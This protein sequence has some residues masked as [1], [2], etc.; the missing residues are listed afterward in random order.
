MTAQ[1]PLLL[2]LALDRA[3]NPV[4]W[5][6]HETA[7]HL[8]SNDRVL[9]PMSDD[10]RTFYGGV[11]AATGVRSRV[12][13]SSIL[14]TKTRVQPHLWAAD[15]VP[16][17]TNRALF[18]RDDNLCLY[19]G[20]SFPASRLTRDHVVP[21]SRNGPDRWENVVTACRACNAQ[22]G[23]RTPA[24]WGR[25]LIA[26]PYAP[27]YAEHLLLRNRAVRADQMAYLKARVRQ[28]KGVRA[29]QAQDALQ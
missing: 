19:C 14:L 27:C 15:Y 5:L 10:V 13:V 24:Q 25:E 26:V 16:P 7:I 28:R 6:D 17:L 29:R 11:N 1:H 2:V 8:I 18:A 22:K 12:D 23:A 4:S 9:A 20:G 3:G 21:R